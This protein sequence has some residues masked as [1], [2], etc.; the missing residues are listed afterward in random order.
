MKNWS[1]ALLVVSCVI[2]VA[3]LVPSIHKARSL[4]KSESSQPSRYIFVWSGDAAHKSSDFLAVVDT[5]RSSAT[6]ARIVSTL[7]VGFSGLMPH[8][9]EY[10]FPP[11]NVLFANGWTGNR[12]FLFDLNE[13]LQPRVIAQFQDRN[14]YTFPHS[15]SRMPNGHVL[16]TFQSYGEGYAPGGG[17]VE[18]NETGAAVRSASAIDPHVDKDLIWPYSLAVLPQVDRVVS[19]STPMGWTDWATLPRN[20]WSVEKINALETAQ[21]QVWRLSDLHLLKTISLVDDGG[22]KHNLLPSEP[23]VMPD[24]SVLINTFS[25]GLFRLTD[26][27]SG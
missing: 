23:R 25:C 22:G 10:E 1:S 19:T 11:G 12:T 14:G 27:K 5:D 7:P 20:S 13:P 15:F 3:L 4:N 16:A 21:I 24:G 18:L 17:L 2:S 26:I 8:H 9:T 6:Y